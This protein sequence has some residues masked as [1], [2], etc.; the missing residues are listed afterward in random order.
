MSRTRL[1]Y[2]AGPVTGRPHRNEVAFAEAQ[3]LLERD[4][5]QVCNPLEVVPSSS[6]WLGAM[7]RC[8]WHLSLCDELRLLPGWHRSRGARCEVALAV[9]LGLSI[10]PPQDQTISL[11]IF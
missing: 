9:L 6:S 7:V 5:W 1:V 3:H 10:F 4:G 8:L 11:D 2:L